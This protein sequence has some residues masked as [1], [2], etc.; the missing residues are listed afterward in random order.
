LP[1]SRRSFVCVLFLCA[2]S[3]AL[4]QSPVESRLLKDLQLLTSDACEGR[5]IQTKG[6]EIAADYIERQFVQAGLQPGGPDGSYT[7][8]FALT[9]EGMLGKKN[10]LVLRG[11]LGQTVTLDSGKNCTILLQGGSDVA[12]GDLVFAGYGLTGSDPA[13]DDYAG[14]DVAGKIGVVLG[15]TPRRGHPFA[16]LFAKGADPGSDPASLR[17]KAETARK[18][19]AAGLLVVHPRSRGTDI[20][21][22]AI[23]T[24]G[25]F[26]PWDLPLAHVPRDLVS[27]MVF[28]A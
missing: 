25:D 17:Q 2:T 3:P 19:K 14:L 10:G 28:A 16:D 12:E 18:H 26:A 6:I 11:P 1:L 27:D 7:Q 21:P 8:R 22:K 9:S 5:G 20:L 24:M 13:Y 23:M 4:A 15:D